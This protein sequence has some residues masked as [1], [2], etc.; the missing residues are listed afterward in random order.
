MSSFYGF[1][2]FGQFFGQIQQYKMADKDGSHSQMI[3]QLLRHVTSS[4][5]DTDVKGGIFRRTISPPGIL[6]VVEDQKRLV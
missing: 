6:P 2:Y 3:T 1:F 4:S 5:H